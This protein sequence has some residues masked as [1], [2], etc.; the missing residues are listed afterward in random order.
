MANTAET[1]TSQKSTEKAPDKAPEKPK[2]TT[3]YKG[4]AERVVRTQ[5][6]LVAAKFDGWTTSKPKK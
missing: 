2:G 3:L 5:D 6:D 1:S 4:D